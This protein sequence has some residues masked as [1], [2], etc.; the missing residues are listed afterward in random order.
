MMPMLGCSCSTQRQS[1]DPIGYTAGNPNLYR[2]AESNSANLVDPSGEIIPI[3]VGVAACIYFFWPDTANAPA[4]GE[5]CRPSDP[6]GGLPWA[7]AGGV[8]TGLGCG[9]GRRH[10]GQPKRLKQPAFLPMVID[11]KPGRDSSIWLELA[12]CYGCRSATACSR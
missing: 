10:G 1:H 2:Y 11:D 8:A 4:P 3:V 9:F 5:P 6:H 7:V 12:G